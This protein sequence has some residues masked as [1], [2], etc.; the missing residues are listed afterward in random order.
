MGCDSFVTIYFL[1]EHDKVIN[2]LKMTSYKQR[3]LS[4]VITNPPEAKSIQVCF[5]DDNNECECEYCN[6][7]DEDEDD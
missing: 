2:K 6:I 5:S 4:Q 3:A 1:D 7:D